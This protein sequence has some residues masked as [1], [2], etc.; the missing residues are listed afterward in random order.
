MNREKFFERFTD[1]L[2][3]SNKRISEI[4][5][6]TGISRGT[7]SS[8]KRKI[9]TPNSKNLEKIAQSLGV[10]ASWLA[11]SDDNNY[12]DS[13]YH[14]IVTILDLYTKATEEEREMIDKLLKMF[15]E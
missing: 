12:A 8:Y 10:D 1:T 14:N 4:A 7:I 9:S 3:K 13:Q 6:E 5:R 2:I 11:G 15:K